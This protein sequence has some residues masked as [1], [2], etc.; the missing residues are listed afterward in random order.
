MHSDVRLPSSG[1]EETFLRHGDLAN[2]GI[3]KRRFVLSNL[4]WNNSVECEGTLD[5]KQTKH[6]REGAD[7]E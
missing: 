3:Q 4:D 2:Q 5:R 6:N 1:R 7:L